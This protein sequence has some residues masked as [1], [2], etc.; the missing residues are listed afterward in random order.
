MGSLDFRLQQ[1]TVRQAHTAM[2]VGTDAILLGAWVAS[3]DLS[4]VRRILD[5]GTGTGIL[6]LMLAQRYPSATVL[7]VDIEAGALIDAC[8]NVASSPFA[9]QISVLEQSFLSLDTS[10][11]YDL[12]ISNPPYYHT[13][14]ISS[15]T[16]SRWL[17]RQEE[18][19]GLGLYSLIS[20]A[21][22]LVEPHGCLCLV[23]PHDR[24]DDV[25]LY[26]TQS[27]LYIEHLCLVYSMPEVP[28]RYLACLRPLSLSSIYIPTQHHHLTIR[29]DNG[30]YT[31]QYIHLTRSY[32]LGG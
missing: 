14:G 5:V 29:L 23:F 1:F 3:L 28:I 2:K 25:R 16:R 4:P 10:T 7:G 27:L 13:S 17:A 8:H 24:L 18:A 6:A 11:R 9:H 30:T 12:I 31:S 15:P 20:R 21:S 32:L 22:S 26:A 19:Q